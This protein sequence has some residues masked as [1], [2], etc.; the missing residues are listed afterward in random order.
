[1]DPSKLLDDAAEVIETRG[2]HQGNYRDPEGE[3]VCSMGALFV[4]RH[5]YANAPY[6]KGDGVFL[7]SD[8]A[9]ATKALVA[10]F[11]EILPD[12]RPNAFTCNSSQVVVEINDEWLDSP[13]VVITSMQ[14]AAA[15]LREK[16]E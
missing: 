4:A 14:K 1:M 16:V 5:G 2:W 9:V 8:L 11:R 6:V 3:G 10:Q 7:D 13:E 15:A 12:Y